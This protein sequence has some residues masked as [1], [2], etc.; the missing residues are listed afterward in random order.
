MPKRSSVFL[1]I[2]LAAPTSAWRIAGEAS[3]SMMMPTEL[4]VLKPLTFMPG[5]YREADTDL[6]FLVDCN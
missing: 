1:I 2:V 5:I 4:P 3:T 6:M